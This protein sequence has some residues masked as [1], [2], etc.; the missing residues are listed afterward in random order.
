MKKFIYSNTK[1]ALE[2]LAD[3]NERITSTKKERPSGEIYHPD[4]MNGS[5]LRVDRGKSFKGHDASVS[6]CHEGRKLFIHNKY[7]GGS[8]SSTFYTDSRTTVLKFEHNYDTPKWMEK[9]MT[10][11]KTHHNISGPVEFEVD[12]NTDLILDI[13]GVRIFKEIEFDGLNMFGHKYN[14][15]ML[16]DL[17]EA[18]SRFRKQFKDMDINR[19]IFA[20]KSEDDHTNKMIKW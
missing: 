1:L 16:R 20:K 5:I 8:V 19:M 2:V 11:V 13:W 7:F 10:E 4:N 12:N 3:L 18:G 14:I 9:K 15:H 17:Q 6:I